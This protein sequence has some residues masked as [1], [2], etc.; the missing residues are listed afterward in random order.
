MKE[1]LEVFRTRISSPL[2]GYTVFAFI[3]INW[4]CLFYLF[5]SETTALER[6]KYFEI[7]TT[8]NSLFIFPLILGIVG[9]IAYPWINFC[10][11][12]ICSKPTDLINEAQANTEH[13]HLLKKLAFEK[14]RAAMKAEEEQ[15]LIEEAKRDNE[16]E[17]IEDPD[18][19][20]KLKYKIEN[21]RSQRDESTVINTN[22]SNKIFKPSENVYLLLIKESNSSEERKHYLQE[23]YDNNLISEI[24]FIHLI[25]KADSSEERQYYLQEI[26]KNKV[27]A[28]PNLDSVLIQ[29][30]DSAEERHHYL[31]KFLK[32]ESGKNDHI[33]NI[34][35][36]NADSA[37]ERR[38]YITQFYKHNPESQQ[39]DIYCFLINNADSAEERQHYL[40]KI[41]DKGLEPSA[42]VFETL[43][44]KSNS[45][46]EK[47]QYKQKQERQKP[48]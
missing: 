11:L 6:I 7:N 26:Y 38:Y 10:L 22:I 36:N 31:H 39:Q 15:Q 47:L 32:N 37:E 12:K 25:L 27:K 21:L 40:Q 3:V 8:I 19:K 42:R 41:Y 20:E 48:S 43:L 16:V 35:I 2:F 28:S 46:E 13:N 29:E 33:F 44:N 9:T 34:F 18:V 17:S 23:I 5:A 45:P 4:K 14:I 24:I 1:M 30:S